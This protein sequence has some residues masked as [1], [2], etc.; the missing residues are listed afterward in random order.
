MFG[1]N[2]VGEGV[3]G[4]AKEERVGVDEPS[5]RLGEGSMVWLSSLLYGY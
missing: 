5:A 2:L 1:S 4:G 3:A